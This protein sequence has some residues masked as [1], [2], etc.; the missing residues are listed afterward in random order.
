[1][2]ISGTLFNEV[3]LTILQLHLVQDGGI[4]KPSNLML[5]QMKEF[6]YNIQSNAL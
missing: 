5:L 4:Y 1:M 6:L 2:G 3:H